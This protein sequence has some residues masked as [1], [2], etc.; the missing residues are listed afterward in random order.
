M[1][2]GPPIFIPVILAK[3]SERQYCSR[4]IEDLQSRIY[5]ILTQKRWPLPTS[6]L[7]RWLLRP[8][9]DTWKSSRSPILRISNP[10]CSSCV[11]TSRSLPRTLIPPVWFPMVGEKTVALCFS[12]KIFLAGFHAASRVHRCCHSVSSRNRSSNSEFL[13]PFRDLRITTRVSPFYR[14]FLFIWFWDFVGL[15]FLRFP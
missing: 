4:I 11:S 8:S 14:G 1:T 5:P 7:L 6:A 12:Y 3:L 15:D 10:Y 2:V 13:Q 9:S